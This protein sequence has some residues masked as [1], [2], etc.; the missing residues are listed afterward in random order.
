M[1]I[2]DG[3]ETVVGLVFVNWSFGDCYATKASLAAS[4]GGAEFRLGS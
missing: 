1:C 3:A 2:K 4:C